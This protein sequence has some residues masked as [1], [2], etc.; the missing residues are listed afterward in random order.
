[1]AEEKDLPQ[2]EHCEEMFRKHFEEGLK[3]SNKEA[4]ETAITK[5]KW[6]APS[7]EEYFSNSDDERPTNPRKGGKAL[8][9][10]RPLYRSKDTG[11]RTK[12]DDT[13][14]SMR[15]SLSVT[16]DQGSHSTTKDIGACCST[17]EHGV[18][19]TKIDSQDS[20][21][22]G[23]FD[24][25]DNDKGF[26]EL[27]FDTEEGPVNLGSLAVDLQGTSFTKPIKAPLGK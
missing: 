4:V 7:E 6:R 14:S 27:V 9:K 19:H 25:N 11:S 21:S 3:S 2:K 16:R 12:C 23:M 8:C 5:R 15:G 13:L 20:F 1:M 22:L 26:N 17:R 10:T 18:L 24:A